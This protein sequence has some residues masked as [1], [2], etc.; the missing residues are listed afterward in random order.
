[1]ES[2]LPCKTKEHENPDN[3]EKETKMEVK[4]KLR[5]GFKLLHKPFGLLMSGLMVFSSINISGVQNVFATGTE[6]GYQARTSQSNSSMIDN[7][8][9]TNNVPAYTVETE[10]ARAFSLSLR[11]SMKDGLYMDRSTLVENKGNVRKAL[12]Y[13]YDNPNETNFW[14]DS[15]WYL[16]DHRYRCYI[17][18]LQKN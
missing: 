7:V 5:R 13:Y 8:W 1:M 12:N 17:R 4:G 18:N 6:L 3:F 10:S 15:R 14:A 9:D 16:T 2:G 11:G